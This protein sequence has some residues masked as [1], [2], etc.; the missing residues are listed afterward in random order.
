MTRDEVIK[1][2]MMIQAAYPNYKPQDKTVA[3]N[4]WHEMLKE[5][6]ADMVMVALK[7]FISSDTSGFAPSVGQILGKLQIVANSGNEDE[8][9]A[10]AAWSLVRKALNNGTYGAEEEF[11]KLPPLAQKVVGNASNLRHWAQTDIS[12]VETVIGSN[13]QSSYKALLKREEEIKKIP[14]SLRVVMQERKL[15][16]GN[17]ESI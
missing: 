17:G 7:A 15:L 3:V 14:E 5:Y 11:A 9:T 12:N 13:F 4:I 6:D 1:L 8:L 2:L 10:P 16:D